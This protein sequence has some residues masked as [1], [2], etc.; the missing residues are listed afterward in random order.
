[1]A[2][3]RVSHGGVL[4]PEHLQNALACLG[5]GQNSGSVKDVNENDVNQSDVEKTL[6]NKKERIPAHDPQLLA[7]ST[8]ASSESEDKKATEDEAQERSRANK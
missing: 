6:R 7:D 2:Q 4:V 3:M 1:M 5:A 8:E